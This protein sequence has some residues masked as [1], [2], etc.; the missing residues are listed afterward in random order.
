MIDISRMNGDL[1]EIILPE[2]EYFD[3]VLVEY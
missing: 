1:L 2:L 3:V